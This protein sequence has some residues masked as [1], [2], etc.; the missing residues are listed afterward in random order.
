M[1]WLINDL[2]KNADKSSLLF[3]RKKIKQ[4]TLN[5]LS[6]CL[7]RLSSFNVRQHFIV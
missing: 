5:I 3:K 1:V 4:R 7:L 6:L 2:V